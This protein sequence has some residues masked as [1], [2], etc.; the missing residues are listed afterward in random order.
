[1]WAGQFKVGVAMYVG[2][3]LPLPCTYIVLIVIWYTQKGG[4]YSKD[5]SIINKSVTNFRFLEIPGEKISTPRICSI[6]TQ[7][8]H[9]PLR[10]V[11]KNCVDMEQI[12]SVEIFSPSFSRKLQWLLIFRSVWALISM[13]LS[14][15]AFSQQEATLIRGYFGVHPWNLSFLITQKFVKALKI[16]I[17]INWMFWEYLYLALIDM[18]WNLPNEPNLLSLGFLAQTKI[19]EC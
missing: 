6:S 10:S 16:Y 15:A 13:Y 14:I 4:K 19:L 2:E 11:W 17:H 8:F 1:M 9:T 18:I 5:W 7:N 3:P 12:L